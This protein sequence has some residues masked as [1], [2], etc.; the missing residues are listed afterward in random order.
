M[1]DFGEIPWKKA[2]TKTGLENFGQKHVS[3]SSK[4]VKM[5]DLLKKRVVFGILAFVL[6]VG[7]A[8]AVLEA[9]SYIREKDAYIEVSG[10]KAVY[11]PRTAKFVKLNGVVRS[12]VKFSSALSS[13]EEVC[14]CPKCCDGYCYII[15]FTDFGTIKG[16]V[17]TLGILWM[18]C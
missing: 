1:P 16:P 14:K 11:V 8:F 5:K 2:R 6:F 12:I 4:E 17:V 10:G 13:G 7:L 18:S 15:V 9:G 3:L